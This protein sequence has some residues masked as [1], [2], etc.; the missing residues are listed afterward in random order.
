MSH[1]PL[2]VAT[3]KDSFPNLYLINATRFNIFLFHAIIREH[4]VLYKFIPIQRFGKPPC[5]CALWNKCFKKKSVLFSRYLH[6]NILILLVQKGRDLSFHFL[7]FLNKFYLLIALFTF[8]FCECS[9]IFFINEIF[10]TQKL[11]GGTFFIKI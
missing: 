7:N 4:C 9:T 1:K 3:A 6:N 5:Y 11:T 2:K 10:K 8:S